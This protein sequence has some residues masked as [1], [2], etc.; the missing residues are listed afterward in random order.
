M[1]ELLIKNNQ[2]GEFFLPHSAPI[3]TAL[4]NAGN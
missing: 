4:P 2:E 1:L 3:A